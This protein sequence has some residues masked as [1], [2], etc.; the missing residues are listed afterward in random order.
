MISVVQR[1]SRAEVRVE[2]EAVG[3]IGRGLLA[4]V[5][6]MRGDGVEDVEYTADRLMHLR[7][8]SDDEGRMNRGIEEVGGNFLVIS[9]FTLAGDTRKGRRPS[10]IKAA[11]PEEAEALFDALVERLRAG[12]VAVETGV[13]AA[14]MEVDLVNDG[15]VT[16][17]LDSQQ[18]RRG[19]RREREDGQGS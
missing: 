8:F 6:V 15:P 3:R 2:G 11:E 19:G 9:Q 1:V 12:P 14:L 4:L 16:L 17:I 10:F 5:A 13:F 18:T 7:I